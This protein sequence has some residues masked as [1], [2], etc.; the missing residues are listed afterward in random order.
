M[1]RSFD[2]RKVEHGKEETMRNILLAISGL[3]PQI[4]TETLFALAVKKNIE[5]D[6]LFILTTNR[7]K[8]VLEGKDKAANTPNVPLAREIKN[9][10]KDYGLPVPKFS[11]RTNVITAEEESFKLY[12]VRTDKDNVLF[13]NKAAE[14]IGLLTSD[15]QTAI[16]A[17]LS[18]GRKSMSAHLALVLSLFARS[19]DKLYHVITDEKFESKNFYP[20][21]EEEKSALVLAEIPFVRLRSLNSPILKGNKKY[22]NIVRQT[23]RRLRLLTDPQKLLLEI[24]N[25]TLRFGGNEII[26]TPQ[27]FVLYL[28]FVER[29]NRNE[30]PVSKDE[31]ISADFARRLKENLKEYFNYYFD[32]RLKN[33]WSEK[34]LDFERFLSLKSK[35][36][37][38]IA[39]LFEEEETREEFEISTVKRQ[40]GASQFSIRAPKEKLAIN[41]E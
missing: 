35:V 36:N 18:G 22:Y 2:L 39:N 25:R 13:P 16:H 10:C 24:K 8:K 6:E 28:E 29:K 9:L 5:I 34:G 3:T 40:Y 38:K 20:K 32:S 19:Q 31:V 41:Y 26:L 17:S 12:D 11:V 15:P 21:T 7:G 4:V 14:I 27:E 23:Q 37:K 1:R 33:H 30:R